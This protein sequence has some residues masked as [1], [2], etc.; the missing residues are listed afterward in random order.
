MFNCKNRRSPYYNGIGLFIGS[1]F[2]DMH[3]IRFYSGISATEERSLFCCIKRRQRLLGRLTLDTTIDPAKSLHHQEILSQ[4]SQAEN[5]MVLAHLPLVAEIAAKLFKKNRFFLNDINDLHSAGEEGLVLALRQFRGARRRR[6]ATFAAWPIMSAISKTIRDQRWMIGIP[7]QLYRRLMNFVKARHKLQVA[8]GRPP[9][10][11]EMVDAMKLEPE[12]ITKLIDWAAPQVISLEDPIG[13]NARFK[14]ADVIE[15]QSISPPNMSAELIL[16]H[17]AFGRL[18]S[19][20]PERERIIIEGRF[21]LDGQGHRSQLELA[22]QFVLS[23]QA[24]GIIERKAL[25]QIREKLG[26]VMQRRNAAKK[27]RR[28]KLGPNKRKRIA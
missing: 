17:G 8:L 5:R 2:S 26:I 10:L 22:N 16:L 7:S 14:V 6:F 1:I 19:L 24:I 23:R 11:D 27:S 21:G 13:K 25:D 18:L 9:S 3:G 15:D 28:S 4:G 20:L 12:A